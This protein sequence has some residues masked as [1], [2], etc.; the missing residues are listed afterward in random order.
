ME[1]LLFSGLYFWIALSLAIGM[2]GSAKGRGG[3]SYFFGSLLFSPLVVGVV[4]LGV[5]AKPDQVMSSETV[6]QGSTR[7]G[8]LALVALTMVVGI[9]VVMAYLNQGAA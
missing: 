2:V 3:F 9:G 4:A 7:E 8:A 1:T 5:P 6:R